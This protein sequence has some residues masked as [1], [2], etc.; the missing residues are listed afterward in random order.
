MDS[1]P[2]IKYSTWLEINNANCGI[3][4]SARYAAFAKWKKLQLSGTGFISQDPSTNEHVN[5]ADGNIEIRVHFQ[6]NRTTERYVLYVQ[7]SITIE[8]LKRTLYSIVGQDPPHCPRLMYAGKQ[9][10][11]GSTLREH[12]IQGGEI[13]MGNIGRETTTML[14]LV[15]V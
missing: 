14:L 4:I 1:Q 9:L 15:S 8:E 10:E 12:N 11:D 3:P 5:T 13:Y 2:P 6:Q 7:T